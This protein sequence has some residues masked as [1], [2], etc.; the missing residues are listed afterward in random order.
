MSNL[1]MLATW[2]TLI[3]VII[4]E[5]GRCSV[6]SGI[7]RALGD[8]GTFYG[9]CFLDFLFFFSSALA[10]HL[11]EG[12]G[13]REGYIGSPENG[14]SEKRLAMRSSNWPGG[15]DHTGALEMQFPDDL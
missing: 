7:A 9:S 4:L 3:S 15:W 5:A 2:M 10:I 8:G 14:G 12:P 13:P 11:L 1:L 6:R